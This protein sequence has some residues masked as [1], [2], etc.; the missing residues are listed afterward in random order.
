MPRDRVPVRGGLR[1]V[2]K[3]KIVRRRIQQHGPSAA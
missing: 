1:L 3:N 2:V